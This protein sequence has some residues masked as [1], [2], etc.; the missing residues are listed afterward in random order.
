[1]TESGE[2]GHW[3]DV[4]MYFLCFWGLHKSKKSLVNLK[5]NQISLIRC[6]ILD[7][8]VITFNGKS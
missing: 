4:F 5:D 3:Q 1:M 8:R 7:D 6:F 2:E